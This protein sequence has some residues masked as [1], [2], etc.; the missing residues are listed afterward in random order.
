MTYPNKLS[1]DVRHGSMI[2]MQATRQDP[3][4]KKGGESTDVSSKERA[5]E[6]VNKEGINSDRLAFTVC[7]PN[8][9]VGSL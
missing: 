9:S 6:K 2:H 4:E 8:T 7:N 3:R 5:L 1:G